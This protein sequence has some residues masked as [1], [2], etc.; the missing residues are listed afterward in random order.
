MT[1]VIQMRPDGRYQ[2]QDLQRLVEE[3]AEVVKQQEV[4]RTKEAAAFLGI[5]QSQLYRIQSCL[6]SHQVP[7]IAG[8]IFLRSELIDFIKK[9]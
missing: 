9:H 7:G 3:L 4:M 6:P 8:R 5:S 2:N 1:A